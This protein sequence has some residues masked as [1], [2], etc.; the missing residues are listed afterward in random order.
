MKKFFKS[1]LNG[2]K[3]IVYPRTTHK[4]SGMSMLF[5]LAIF[6]ACFYLSMSSSNWTV[7]KYVNNSI[8]DSY[9]LL[10]EDKTFTV[11]EGDSVLPTLEYK[12]DYSG[13]YLYA[14]VKSLPVADK[15]VYDTKIKDNHGKVT[16][17]KFVYELDYLEETTTSTEEQ[18]IPD[19]YLGTYSFLLD[20]EE[21]VL[22]IAKNGVG[23]YN[24]TELEF[25]KVDETSIKA[26]SDDFTVIVSIEDNKVKININNIIIT[27]YTKEEN[28]ATFKHFDLDKYYHEHDGYNEVENDLVVIYTRN[29]IYYLFNR[30]FTSDV[31]EDSDI[32]ANFITL[33]TADGGLE[34]DVFDYFL[35][36]NKHEAQADPTTW[37]TPASRNDVY[38]NGD[39]E[40]KPYDRITS[41]MQR[42]FKYNVPL[43]SY[44]YVETGTEYKEIAGTNPIKVVEEFSLFHI[45]S[46]GESINY[47]TSCQKGIPFG[48]MIPLLCVVFSWIISRKR[49]NLK[50]FK[51]YF[52]V[53]AISFIP[54]ALL[55]FI[56]G[57]FLQYTI[58]IYFLVVLQIGVYIFYIYRINTHKIVEE[59]PSV[60]SN[61][62]L[63]V[64]NSTVVEETKPQEEKTEEENPNM[65]G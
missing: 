41:S 30:G 28:S 32:Y 47:Q 40:V 52:N 36:A 56:L 63:N 51:E 50:L 10:T 61:Q 25:V 26:T 57:F 12:K 60:V 3:Y 7:E 42:L 11:V 62:T 9:F 21:K 33:T 16:N 31:L 39:L 18:I 54:V 55:E 5:G 19:K 1:I 4:L 15:Y 23:F 2:I 35:P 65:I 34:N 8:G 45:V 20:N 64:E 58:F 37:K 24:G 14:K 46:W 59:A 29:I 6:F 38:K 44:N 17:V 53:A 13:N 27:T 22:Q 43:I 49:G 48:I